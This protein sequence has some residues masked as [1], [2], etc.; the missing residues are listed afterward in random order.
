MWLSF[1]SFLP[2]KAS[3]LA[4]FARKELDVGTSASFSRQVSL[5]KNLAPMLPGCMSFSNLVLRVHKL[6]VAMD[7][8]FQALL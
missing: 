4:G 8:Q 5:V 1:S 2:L 7:S 3:D 6:Q